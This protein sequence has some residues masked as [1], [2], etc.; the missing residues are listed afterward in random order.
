MGNAE[1]ETLK[2]AMLALSEQERATLAVDLVT[3]LDGSNDKDLAEAWDIE[4][5]GRI[6]ELEKFPDKLLEPEEVLAR[7]RDRLSA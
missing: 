2:S 6:N 7:A 3:S 4:I 1:L 5:C